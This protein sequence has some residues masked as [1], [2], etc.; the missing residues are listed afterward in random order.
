MT[1]AARR[2]LVADTDK[3]RVGAGLRLERQLGSAA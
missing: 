1:R 2:R 3:E